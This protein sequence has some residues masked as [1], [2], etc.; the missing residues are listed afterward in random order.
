[1]ALSQGDEQVLPVWVRGSRQCITAGS[2]LAV[3]VGILDMAA[4]LQF[5]THCNVWESL[6]RQELLFQPQALN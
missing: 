5:T 6:L 1:M 2:A 4:H 3:I